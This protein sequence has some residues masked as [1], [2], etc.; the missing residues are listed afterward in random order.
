MP[1]LPDPQPLAL[2]SPPP[3]LRRAVARLLPVAVAEPW[4]VLRGGRVNRL[5]R[6]GDVVIK[7]YAPA[8]ASPLFPNDADAEA[9]ALAWGAPLGL[10]PGLLARGAGWI[11]YSHVPGL[12]WE[13]G[14]AV[15]ATALVRI[16]AQPA[17]PFPQ[18]PTG[19][20]AWLSAARQMAPGLPAPADPGVPPLERLH[21]IHGDAVAANLIIG[22]AGA[23]MVDW[24]CPAMA[25]P[26][27]DLATFLS[28]AMQWLYRGAPLTPA[29]H[30]AFLAAYPDAMIVA[31]YRA[32]APVLH[33]RIA[34]HCAWKAAR[35]SAD[36]ARA[37]AL[38]QAGLPAGPV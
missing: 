26:A 1:A 28:P 9:A 33:H 32:L 11:A 36:Y 16:H 31:R 8:G 34:A 22:A 4:T 21:P 29:E 25:D 12:P 30:A 6:V 18:R 37:M 15:A 7:L 24:Q 3:G 19:S 5:W 38:E 17:A 20:A 35:G 13:A 14:P 27:E 23:T 2:D 10:S